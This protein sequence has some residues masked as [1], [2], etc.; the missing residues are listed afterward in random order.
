MKEFI[1]NKKELEDLR[2]TLNQSREI[3]NQK[4]DEICQLK[5]DNNRLT[6]LLKDYIEENAK[7]KKLNKK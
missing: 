1:I 4:T 5:K 2:N 6:A 7:L 3:I